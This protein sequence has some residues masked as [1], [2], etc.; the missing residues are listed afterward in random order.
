M[1]LRS[2]DMM[3]KY[4]FFKPFTNDSTDILLSGDIEVHREGEYGVP[5]FL[6]EMQHLVNSPISK[7]LLG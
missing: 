3:R 1:Y 4:L 7:I 2:I 6:P 5:T